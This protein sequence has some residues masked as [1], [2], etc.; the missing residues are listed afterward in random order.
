MK[1]KRLELRGFKPQ[2]F[3]NIKKFVANFVDNIQII[4]GI[5]GSSK[6]TT[7]G[8]IS[9]LPA[10]KSMYYKNG[11]KK[12]ELEHKG[13]N[14]ILISDFSNKNKVHSFIRN[15]EDLNIGGT[16][17]VQLEL[18]NRYLGYTSLV[19]SILHN[20]T[21]I[22]S[23]SKVDRRALLLS[24]NPVD[25]SLVIEKHKYVQS[26]LREDKAN[27]KLLYTRKQ[28]LEATIL[29]KEVLDEKYKKKEMYTNRLQ[30][31]SKNEFFL[32]YQI[33]LYKHKDSVKDICKN[34]YNLLIQK[35]DIDFNQ[36]FGISQLEKDINLFSY[37]HPNVDKQDFSKIYELTSLLKQKKNETNIYVKLI[38]QSLDDINQANKHLKEIELT[39]EVNSYEK[40]LKE[41]QD[42]YKKYEN[43]IEPKV[44]IREEEYEYYLKLKDTIINIMNKI[45]AF[46]M[47]NIIYLEDLN[48]CK[49]K[50]DDIVNNKLRLILYQ[51]SQAKLSIEE[52]DKELFSLP[53]DPKEILDNC[54]LCDYRRIYISRSILLKNKKEAIIND[55]KINEKMYDK[56]KKVKNTLLEFIHEQEEVHKVIDI[57]YTILE[58]TNFRLSKNSII[59]RLN[60][61]P[62][63][64]ETTIFT[65]INNYPKIYRKRYLEKEI[66][67]LQDQLKLMSKTN[68]PSVEFIKNTIDKSNKEINKHKSKLLELE[69]EI[70]SIQ[71]ETT[72]Y[73]NYSDLVKRCKDINATINEVFEYVYIEASKTFYTI[74]LD[75]I[76]KEKSEILYSLRELDVELKEQESLVARYQE[77]TVKLIESI[78]KEKKIL[79]EIEFG[80]S[81]S[82]G[83]PHK[84]MIEYLNVLI[85][86][87]NCILDSV[88]SYPMQL[89]PLELDDPLDYSFKVM[90]D[91]VL[92]NDISRLSR[93][94]QV[95]VNLAFTISFIINM[96]LN[97]YPIFF[98]EVIEGLDV[99]HTQR[100]LEWL[101]E[102]V[103]NHYVEQMFFIN[104]DAVLNSGFDGSDLICMSG[105]DG[106]LPN[107]VNKYVTIN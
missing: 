20:E 41:Y 43:L 34:I 76:F 56:Y 89:V 29:T 69:K 12:I 105:N 10:S 31:L 22:C 70:N 9:P 106:S 32:N 36:Y 78:E 38:K 26:K 27:L 24:L 66:N 3:A 85:N 67:K 80:I 93:G 48:K 49:K 28:E 44:I 101:K 103:D 14:Y 98:D 96:Q 75:K 81:P 97:D 63:K 50:I 46:H 16:Q 53:K 82:T 61:D 7:L 55:L 42:E 21:N 84:N 102:I 40:I 87:V 71:I 107:H 30:E 91:E 6:S 64:F 39:N 23:M 25:L 13:D 4:T 100:A 90:V 33:N 73:N 72:G 52:I 2:T 62:G 5:N 99:T 88:W 37:N 8:E 79:E 59:D 19:S 95:I 17:P 77:E 57:L 45:L 54:S 15:G 60:T 58:P 86:N 35:N 92:V 11:Y 104:H 83:F 18:V 74:E 65:I 94:Q 47:N 51:I 68:L 1:I